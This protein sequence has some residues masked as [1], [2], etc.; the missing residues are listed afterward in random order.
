[1]ITSVAFQK[2]THRNTASRIEEDISEIFTSPLVQ[3]IRKKH[4]N[5][6]KIASYEWEDIENQDSED[7]F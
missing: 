6:E 7:V 3:S 2:G 4:A 1:M 5:I